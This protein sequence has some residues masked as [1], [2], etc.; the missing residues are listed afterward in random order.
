LAQWIKALAAKPD[1]PSLFLEPR[2]SKVR[3]YSTLSA[4]LYI[5]TQTHRHTHTDT[6]T[7]RDTDRYTETHTHSTKIN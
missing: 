7:E 5:H 1:N 2:R 3:M 4:D 6:H